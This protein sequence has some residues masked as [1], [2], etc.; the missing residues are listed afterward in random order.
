MELTVVL[1]TNAYSDWRGAGRWHQW[2][3]KADRVLLPAIVLGELF[4]GFRKGSHAGKNITS[5]EAFLEEPQ[6]DLLP[7]S[8][9]TAEIYG[10]FLIHLQKSGTPIP[11][12][13]IWIA[14]GA[15]EVH[16]RLLTRDRHFE[17]LPQVRL[18]EERTD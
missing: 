9:R 15:H 1:D 14:A 17:R 6:V 2:I 3:A 18:A 7:V 5:L 16:A 13:D 11:T 12:N 4:H 10:T 8:R